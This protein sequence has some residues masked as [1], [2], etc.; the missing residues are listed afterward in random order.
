METTIYNLNQINEAAQALRDGQ[1]VAFPTETVYGLGADATNEHA[2]KKVYQAKGRPSDNPLIVHVASVA[3]VEQYAAAIP[4]KA[5][6]LMDAFWPGSLTII[7]K[8]KPGSLSKTVTG[9]LS[10]VAFRFPKCQ[11]T[12]DLITEAGVPMVGPS[13]NTSG[14]PSPT[15]AQHVYHDLHGKIRGILDDGPTQVG[16]ESTVL[17]LSTDQPVILR[18]GAVTKAEIENVIGSIDLN[19]HHVGKGETPKAPGMK[20]KHYAPNAQVYI[21]DSEEDWP[22]VMQWIGNQSFTVG[23]MAEDRI[24]KKLSLPNNAE[25]FSMGNGVDDASARLFDGLRMYDDE[26]QVQAIMTEAFPA[27]DLGLAY[28]NRLN[29]SAG[30]QHFNHQVMH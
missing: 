21:V 25:P 27:H 4:E 1:L 19:H 30:G 13:A 22:N 11:P 3:M 24:L 17:D 29:K 23:V 16:V 7:L 5:R 10:T 8:I 15:T 12:L 14:K 18:P 26:K 28:M 20:Y 2:V 9:G 6:Q